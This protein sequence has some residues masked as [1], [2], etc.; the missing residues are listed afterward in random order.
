MEVSGELGLS[1][2]TYGLITL[3]GIAVKKKKDEFLA[4]DF[5]K[6]I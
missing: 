2:K 5:I 4:K 3:F 6:I 1:R